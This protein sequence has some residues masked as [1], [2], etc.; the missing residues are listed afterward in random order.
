[1]ADDLFGDVYWNVKN[2]TNQIFDETLGRNVSI[3]NES[4][5]WSALGIRPDGTIVLQIYMAFYVK[6]IVYYATDIPDLYHLLGAIRTF[7]YSPITIE[8]A[9]GIEN[10]SHDPTNKTLSTAIR[11][12]ERKTLIDDINHHIHFE[13]INN[14]GEGIYSVSMGS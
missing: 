7:Y 10:A 4:I 9:E 11:R 2:E 13:G 5:N 3:P 12:G 8:D 14:E 1:M 6:D